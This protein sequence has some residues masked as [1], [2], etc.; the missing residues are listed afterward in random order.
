MS[1]SYILTTKR[2][3]RILL[4]SLRFPQDQ[5]PYQRIT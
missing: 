5:P 3:L 4:F 2:D 1:L